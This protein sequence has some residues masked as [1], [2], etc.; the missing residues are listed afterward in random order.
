MNGKIALLIGAA[1]LAFTL[2]PN[3]AQA[4]P[5][6]TPPGFD[7]GKKAG[8]DGDVPP[9]WAKWDKARRHKHELTV[10]VAVK[11]VR[12]HAKNK[13]IT[14]D[15]AARAVRRSINAGLTIELAEGTVTLSIDRGHTHTQLETVARHVAQGHHAGLNAKE[16]RGHAYGL[17]K[18][19]KHKGKALGIALRAE[20]DRRHARRKSAK[21]HKKA[22]KAAGKA[23]QWKAA[24]RHDKASDRAADKG[25][26]KAA[27]GH[28][29]AAKRQRKRG[30][31]GKR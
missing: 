11:R 17:I 28:D 4:Q 3:A 8:W 26:D 12:H 20:H 19:G 2:T 9:G 18:N 15:Q 21:V 14:P 27:K 7:K 22:R 25:H 13:H 31:R 10:A 24:R 1:A 16:I 5:K 6:D 30:K 29:K 23:H